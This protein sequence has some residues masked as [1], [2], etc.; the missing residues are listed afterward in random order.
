MRYYSSR[1]F[2]ASN[3]TIYKNR[4]NSIKIIIPI[5]NSITLYK[6]QEKIYYIDKKRR[7]L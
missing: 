6:R 1:F 7:K 5:F 3:N 4:K 2:C